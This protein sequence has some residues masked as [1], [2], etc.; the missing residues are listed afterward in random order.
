MRLGIPKSEYVKLAET[1]DPSEFVADEWVR[2][3]KESGAEYICFTTKHHDGFCMW[4]TKCTEY[5]ITNTPFGRDILKELSEA[6]ERQGML[7]ELYYSCPDWHYK[8]SVNNGGSHELPC[9]NDG[10]EPNEDKY[11]EYVKA[12]MKELMT[13][14][15]KISG[16]FWDIP[17][18][19]R[20]PS[21]NEL[22]RSLQPDIL[23]NDR[24]Y[25]KGDYS[26]PERDE[27][28]KNA[29]FERLCEACQ[30][31]G[32]QSWGYRENED[33]FTSQGLISSVSSILVKGGNY[34]LNVGPK[35]DGT[36]PVEA[37]R[38]FAGV[39]DWYKRV[40]ESIVDTKF[41]SLGGRNYTYKEN[42]LYLH[43]PA[44]YG[45]SGALLSPIT[46][47]PSKVTLLNDGSDVGYEV[48]YNPF[49]YNGR[50]NTPHL[51]IYGL[52]SEKLV[53][54]NMVVKIEFPDLDTA[55]KTVTGKTKIIL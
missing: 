4:D 39:G 55:F 27:C 35:P 20:D 34:L 43:L 25:D 2:F 45:S 52:P 10:D 21:V 3:A 48:E 51:R 47:L 9:P 18:L 29:S 37:K 42:T 33:Y 32:M 31:V 50:E 6:C 24:G 14:Y 7:L 15:G 1:F 17:P 38:V 5:K 49:D 28:I 30:S 23:I 26:T 16:L 40:R 44:A 36:L 46:A 54:E 22:V 53:S 19:R 12:Q 13:G 41:I 11:V 8:H